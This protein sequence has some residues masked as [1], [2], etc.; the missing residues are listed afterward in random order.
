MAAVA[1]LCRRLGGER[2]PWRY[3]FAHGQ[4]RC[5]E[6]YWVHL[7]R[8]CVSTSTWTPCRCPAPG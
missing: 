2:L 3:H 8:R 6:Q 7:G 5:I 4:P 1:A